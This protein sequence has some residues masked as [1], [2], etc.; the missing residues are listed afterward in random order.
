MHVKACDPRHPHTQNKTYFL[1][2]TQIPNKNTKI[3]R[4]TVLAYQATTVRKKNEQIS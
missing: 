1:N 4:E 2:Q 3:K